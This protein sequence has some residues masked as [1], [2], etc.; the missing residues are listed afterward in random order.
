MSPGRRTRGYLRGSSEQEL[1]E[2]E[3][4][5]PPQR[6][7][8]CGGQDS[9][10]AVCLRRRRATTRGGRGVLEDLVEGKWG[11]GFSCVH[12]RRYIL[13]QTGGGED[14]G[15][16]SQRLRVPKTGASDGT[17]VLV[18]ADPCVLG[19]SRGGPWWL[20]EQES[21]FAGHR[22]TVAESASA[23]IVS[24]GRAMKQKTCR[25]GYLRSFVL[26]AGERAFAPREGVLWLSQIKNEAPPL[27]G[28]SQRPA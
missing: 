11:R 3:F 16:H 6:S 13:L 2:A 12:S 19:A 14:E 9:E 8:R 21:S 5:S 18:L 15:G 7:I 20:A 23:G 27:K 10:G 26:R 17:N 1:A 22:G 24:E 28:K 25:E 4:P